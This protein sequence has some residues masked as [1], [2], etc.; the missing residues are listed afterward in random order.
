MWLSDLRLLLVCFLIID[1]LLLLVTF[2]CRHDREHEVGGKR[3]HHVDSHPPELDVV[4]QTII[5]D[6]FIVKLF[7]VDLEC[8]NAAEDEVKS[9][10]AELDSDFLFADEEVVL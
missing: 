10:W 3:W 4:Q 7:R 1:S 9:D 8:W 6:K 5:K 2:L